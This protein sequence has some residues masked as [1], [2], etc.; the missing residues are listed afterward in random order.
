MTFLRRTSRRVSTSPKTWSR[1]ACRR[2]CEP[3]LTIYLHR[4]MRI[5]SPALGWSPSIGSSEG[6]AG[7]PSREINAEAF[8]W[9]VKLQRGLTQEE[10]SLLDRWLALDARCLG[11]LARAQAYW[12]HVD[13]G[14][15]FKDT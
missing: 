8:D 6:R 1:S 11:A 12:V 7:M 3:S 9:V 14:K 10:Q 15:H 5:Y 2:H 13:G 4:K